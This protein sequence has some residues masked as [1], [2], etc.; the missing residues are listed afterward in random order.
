ML[1]KLG[2][3]EDEVHFGIEVLRGLTDFSK[4]CAPQDRRQ[5]SLQR[6]EGSRG[7]RINR[8]FLILE[9]EE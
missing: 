6:P 8:H 4:T 7:S 9:V 1:R 5:R 3:W 2:A